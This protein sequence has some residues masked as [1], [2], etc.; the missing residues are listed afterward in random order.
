MRAV[1]RVIRPSAMGL[2]IVAQ[3]ACGSPGVEKV[4]GT[5]RGDAASGT[6]DG[7][8]FFTVPDGGGLERPGIGSE[9]SCASQAF[10]A[11]RLPLDLLILV[12]ASSSMAEPVAGLPR[13]KW[14][15]VQDALFG[16]VKDPMSAGLGIGLQFFPLAGSGT[17]CS[18]AADCGVTA[19]GGAQVCEQHRACVAPGMSPSGA[20]GCSPFDL[21]V[22][23]LGT[24]CQTVGIC[25]MTGVEC[26]PIGTACPG[27][28]AGNSCQ[29][30]PTTCYSAEPV[31]A[32]EAY[33]RLAVP[34]VDLPGAA[35]AFV[36]SM[37]LRRPGGQTPMAQAAI[38]ALNHLRARLAA[39]PRRRAALVIATDGLPSGCGN[40][41]I[42]T[43]GDSLYTARITAPSV[44]TYV[45]G[46]LDPAAVAQGR[47]DF[48]QLSV[49]GGTG[50]PFILAANGDLNQKLLEALNQIRGELACEYVIPEEKKASI[51][52]GK[53]NL[54]FTGAASQE[55]VPYVGRAERCDAT[56][57]GWYYDVDPQ[58]GGTP[59]RVIA[60]PASCQRFRSE[61]T[62]KVELRFGCKTVVIQ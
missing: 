52:F 54:H 25:A 23:P 20:A 18:T 53:V 6:S 44:V 45:I 10:A 30:Q 24:A 11:E 59:G 42:P 26:A 9:P 14:V 43:I 61:P 60:C 16:F 12:D 1:F 55:D 37:S 7:P 41:D 50:N 58:A 21:A 28:V 2:A 34:I 13:S 31:C 39:M 36:R 29:A 32:T 3:L 8:G 46:V 40:Q 47:S 33:A 51:D 49:A 5:P 56:R 62:G 15:T 17:P 48:Q 22:C 35:G 4:G 19:P 27:G 38:G 57:G